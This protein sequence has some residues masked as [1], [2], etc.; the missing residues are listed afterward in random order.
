MRNWLKNDLDYFISGYQRDVEM[1]SKKDKDEEWKRDH[2]RYAS[3][4]YFQRILNA[5]NTQIIET[6]PSPLKES[7]RLELIVL[8][9]IIDQMI[10]S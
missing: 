10:E 3:A 8:R 5:L 7:T 1:I 9:N 6:P 2:Y 4:V